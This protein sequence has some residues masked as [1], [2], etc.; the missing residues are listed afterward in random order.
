ML[1]ANILLRAALGVRTRRLVESYDGVVAFYVPDI[2]F[3]EAQRHIPTIAN[4]RGIDTDQA[5]AR[6]VQFRALVEVVDQSFYADEREAATKR[7]AS[8]DPDDWPIAAT[9]LV[10]NCPIWTED[11]D[12][13][14]SGIATW[15]TTNV[16]LYLRER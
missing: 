9:A 4:K 6:I 8:R 12:F 15:T 13:F 7:M 3:A 10:L 11:Q 16:E 2:C 1:D 14:G 5:M